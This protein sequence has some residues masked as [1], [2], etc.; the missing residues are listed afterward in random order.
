MRVSKLTLEAE[1]KIMH[2]C[3][4][5]RLNFLCPE[6]CKT[7][8]F[9]HTVKLQA[10]FPEKVSN[11]SLCKISVGLCIDKAVHPVDEGYS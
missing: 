7:V 9:C 4:C 1:K 8:K 5:S 3:S 2:R 11:S 10:Y 6:I